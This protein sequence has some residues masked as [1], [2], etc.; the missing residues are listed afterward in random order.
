VLSF[1]IVLLRKTLYISGAA[2]PRYHPAREGEDTE[3]QASS[4]R[5]TG[6]RE[7]APTSERLEVYLS[8]TLRAPDL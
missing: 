8:L 5:A 2:E 3:K 6:I 1:C 7:L 4:E